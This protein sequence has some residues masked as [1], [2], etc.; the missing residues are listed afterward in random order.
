MRQLISSVLAVAAGLMLAGCTGAYDDSE[1]RKGLDDLR[2]R[3][4]QL[5][6][7]LDKLN[8]DIETINALVESLQGGISIVKV[9]EGADGSYTIYFSDNTTAVIRSGSNGEDA[10]VI[11]VREQDGVYYWTLTSDGETTWLTD[12]DG[13][14]L[15]VSGED[16]TCPKLA[17]DDEGWWTVS[18]DGGTVWERILDAEGN[19]VK[20]V[21]D[22]GSSVGD[23]FFSAVSQ[24]D[25]NVYFTL[26][27]GSVITVAKKGDF[28]LIL[29]E[30]PETS[31]FTFGQVKTYE[32]ESNG[33]AETLVA[34]R[35]FGWTVT[36][37]NEVLT[38]A[39]PAEDAQMYESEGTVGI[40]YSDGDERTSMVQFNVLLTADQTGVTEGDDFTVEI[41][42]VTG[43]GV[44]ATVTAKDASV[45]YYV[46]AYDAASFDE[47]GED[48][49][50]AESKAM[51]DYYLQ[52]GMWDYYRDMLMHSGTYH[53]ETPA[54]TP[55]TA[56]QS[57][58]L[59]VFGLEEDASGQ[60]LIPNTAVMKVPFTTTAEEVVNTSYRVSL[61]NI[62]WYGLDYTVVPS[63]DL[64]YFHGIVSQSAFIAEDGT[65]LTAAQ[66]AEAYVKD[67]EQRYYDELYLT[68]GQP[69]AWT[70]LSS[71]G[72]QEMSVP[73]A[74][75]RENELANEEIRPLVPDTDYCLLV[76]GVDGKDLRTDVVTKEFHTP[77][78]QP[79]ENGTFELEVTVSRQNLNIKVT[80][81]DPD[82]SYI[83]HV[84]R[85]SVYEEFEDDMQFAADDLFWAKY[86]G[87]F[88][89]DL[90]SGEATLKAENLWAST[91]Y[92][93]YVYGCTADGVITT[94]LTVTRV[95]TEAGS[96]NPP[97]SGTAARPMTARVR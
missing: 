63:D 46:T 6:S 61:S 45:Y 88:D 39:A 42:E 11:G 52:F 26:A 80:P 43:T 74:W 20:A 4:E 51:F 23:S 59:I 65:R 93:V 38:V 67:Y 2:D 57:Y 70:D 95:L 36:L 35:P 89:K 96:D 16:G 55:L 49:V 60:Q 81:S 97:V 78:F 33:V 10:P 29:R 8:G 92:V 13:Q 19:P 53:Y 15:P 90:I 68:D 24:D 34:A 50:V 83:C 25:E 9:E 37:E 32:V 94:P 27:D 12:A 62:T 1:L 30:V 84:D 54:S 5:E 7:K 76:F 18:Y 14:P 77:A 69:L 72:T 21:T 71:H 79:L 64:H 56:G 48:A 44:A 31:V 73:R 87:T 58:Y 17:V 91:G 28:Y 40:I 82:M 66:V 3:V 86:N 47:K 75:I 22:E 85:S 41:T